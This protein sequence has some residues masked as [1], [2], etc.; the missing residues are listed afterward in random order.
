MA[1]IE[2]GCVTMAALTTGTRLNRARYLLGPAVHKAFDK[3]PGTQQQAHACL[4][5]LC[6]QQDPQRDPMATDEA[7]WRL[8][9]IPAGGSRCEGGTW[10]PGA[11]RQIK[12]SHWS[13]ALCRQVLTCEVSS[14]TCAS[15]SQAIWSWMSGFMM[16]ARDA[17]MKVIA[18]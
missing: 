15:R 10:P 1:G 13:T 17:S 3:L 14:V 8:E 4:R 16:P 9:H 7:E 18:L 2:S 6:R 12:Q 5:E 11:C